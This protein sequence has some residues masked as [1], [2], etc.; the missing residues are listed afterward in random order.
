MFLLLLLPFYNLKYSL[1]PPSFS[2]GNCF[3]AK[4]PKSA[5][6]EAVTNV[7]L[8]WSELII[9]IAFPDK[10]LNAFPN[11]PSVTS[12]MTPSPIVVTVPRLVPVWVVVGVPA[13]RYAAMARPEAMP[14]TLGCGIDFLIRLFPLLL[15][16][17]TYARRAV[18]R[19]PPFLVDR[20]RCVARLEALKAL[21][22][23]LKP[24]L[25]YFLG[26]PGLGT[27]RDF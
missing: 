27:R 12:L 13:F 4:A 6:P 20:L 14:V 8:P 11:S 21:H 25:A 3:L 15:F 1:L 19:T 9:L 23:F 22:P 10:V 17:R 2:C 24:I 16:L 18:L 7:F 26:S 5:I